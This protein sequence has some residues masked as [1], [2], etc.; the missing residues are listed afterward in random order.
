MHRSQRWHRP[1]SCTLPIHRPP[2]PERR[3]SWCPHRSRQRPPPQPPALARGPRTIG[4]LVALEE[5]VRAFGSD[6]V[7]A[8]WT[9]AYA[10]TAQVQVRRGQ[11]RVIASASRRAEWAPSRC[12]ELRAS[13]SARRWDRQKVREGGHTDV[14]LSSATP[15]AMLTLASFHNAVSSSTHRTACSAA[16]IGAW[17]RAE[18]VQGML[19]RI[20]VAPQL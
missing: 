19:E 5:T 10:R 6:G 1:R 12:P 2:R 17:D 4:D 15:R 8:Q 9:P 14:D 13:C 18:E 20:L 7:T 16:P 11:S 3:S